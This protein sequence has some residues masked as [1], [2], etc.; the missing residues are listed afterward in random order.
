MLGWQEHE[1]IGQPIHELVQHILPDGIPF[2]AEECP[3]FKVISTGQP[4][5]SHGCFVTREDRFIPIDYR[6]RPIVIEDKLVG[7]LVS[8]QD[9]SERKNSEKFI[10]LT[11]ERLNLSLEA[12][13]LAL[14]DWDIIHDRIFFSD[15]WS[16]MMGGPRQEMTLTS[17]QLF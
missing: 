2:P 16:M 14:W 7:A 17:N 15:R 1:L 6:C 9:V 10:R 5:D 4:I 8:F 11:Q 13:N 12:S 3:Q